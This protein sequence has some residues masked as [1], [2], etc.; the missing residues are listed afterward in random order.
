MD[1]DNDI[2]PSLNMSISANTSNGDMKTQTYEL[3]HKRLGHLGHRNMKYMLSTIPGMDWKA[4]RHHKHHRHDVCEGCI[5]GKQHRKPFEDSKTQWGLMNL[6]HSN[7]MG[8]IRVP[9]LNNSKYV[10]TFIE[11]KSRYP[12]CYFI[13]NKDADTILNCFKEY[14]A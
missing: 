14:K 11:H 7:I 6:V 4:L 10:L 1:I 2:Q 8:P 13:C 9:S 5:Y 12:K 3:W